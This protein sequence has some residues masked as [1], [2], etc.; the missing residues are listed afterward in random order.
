[1][2]HNRYILSENQCLLIANKM[3]LTK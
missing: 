1:M 3:Q 2:D